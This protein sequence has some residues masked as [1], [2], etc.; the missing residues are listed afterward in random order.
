[1]REILYEIERIRTSLISE[2]ELQRVQDSI[3][4]SLPALFETT[5]HAASSI[6]QLFVHG[7]ELD[8]YRQLPA[9]VMAVTPADVQNVA[10]K[11][12]RPEGLVVV[13]VGDRSLIEPQLT[14]LQFGPVEIRDL[15]G[16]P[17]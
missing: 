3:A 2:E 13:A 12:L 7:L 9:D 8:Y 10:E 11:Y 17:V 6:G 5:P 16:K 1:V 15:D 4:R 14:G